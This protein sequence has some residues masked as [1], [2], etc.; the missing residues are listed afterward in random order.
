MHLLPARK[1]LPIDRTEYKRAGIFA[2]GPKA[3]GRVLGRTHKN[4]RQN[5]CAS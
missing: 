2:L 4:L 1:T 3:S 5:D